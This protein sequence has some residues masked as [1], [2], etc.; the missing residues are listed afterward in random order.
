MEL[1]HAR[2]NTRKYQILSKRAILMSVALIYEIQLVLFKIPLFSSDRKFGRKQSTMLVSQWG[3]STGDAYSSGHLV[4]FNL[5]RNAQSLLCR[6]KIFEHLLVLL[7]YFRKIQ[8][9]AI[10]FEL[11]NLTPRYE[12]ISEALYH[13]PTFQTFG[14]QRKQM[15]K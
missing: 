15:M 12:N 10:G 9:L 14:F 1:E 8:G 11:V 3:M 6:V 7:F 2:H 5:G 13:P 4:P